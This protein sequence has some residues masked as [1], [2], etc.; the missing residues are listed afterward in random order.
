MTANEVHLASKELQK[1]CYDYYFVSYGV[2][3]NRNRELDN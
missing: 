1:S 2:L 3:F